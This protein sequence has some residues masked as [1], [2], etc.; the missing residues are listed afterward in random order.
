MATAKD[1]QAQIDAGVREALSKLGF[2]PP[3]P[4][5]A[6]VQTDHIEFGSDEHREFLGLTLVD[7]DD[8]PTGYTTYESKE[9]G[10]I[11]RLQDEIGVVNLYPG[12]DPEKATILVLRQ[13]VNQLEGGPPEV[14][15]NAPPMWQPVGRGI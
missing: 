9:T 4:S 14:P 7:K 13:K 2:A 12:V 6:T 10:N 15:E 5:G 1:L 3:A 11:Y 8:D